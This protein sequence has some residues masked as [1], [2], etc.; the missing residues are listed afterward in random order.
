[1]ILTNKFYFSVYLMLGL[2]EKSEN[3]FAEIAEISA[4][5]LNI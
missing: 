5:D 3:T 1:M 2:S 4:K